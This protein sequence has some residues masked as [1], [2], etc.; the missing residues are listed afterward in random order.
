MPDTREGRR[1]RWQRRRLDDLFGRGVVLAASTEVNDGSHMLQTVSLRKNA[2]GGAHV[3]IEHYSEKNWDRT[4]DET[5]RDL[6]D[7]R[8]ALEWLES[9]WGVHWSQLDTS[10]APL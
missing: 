1:S 3:H 6:A 2:Q 5:D 10:G 7:L 4:I 9:E 8:A